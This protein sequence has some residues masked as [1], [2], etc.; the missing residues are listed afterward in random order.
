MKKIIVAVLIA[1]LTLSLTACAGNSG[2]A[3]GGPADYSL[4]SAAEA[5]AAAPMMAPDADYERYDDSGG[6]DAGGSMGGGNSVRDGR[7]IT[8]SAQVSLNTK[9][10]D[11]DYSMI[12][13]LID[14]SGGFVASESM[15]DNS[16]MYGRPTGR[17]ANISARVP[18]G[19]YDTFVDAV[20]GIG[21]VTQKNKWSDDLTAEYFDTE[22]RI[23]LLEIRKER[24]MNY[25]LEAD[26]A[27]S[28][29]AFERELSNVLYELD[30]FQGNKRRLD[31]LVDYASVDIYLTELITPETIGKDGE[32]LGDRAREAFSLSLTGVGRFLENFA[33]GFAA[34]VP[35]IILLLIIAAII[36]AIV[37]VTRPLRDKLYDRREAR[38]EKRDARHEARHARRD[39]RRRKQQPYNAQYWQ[40]P[41]YPPPPG[42]QPPPQ[43]PQQPPPTTPPQATTP[44]PPAPEQGQEPPEDK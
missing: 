40:Q 16:A 25:L 43:G 19:D 24:L 4:Y 23:E 9:Q 30:S 8:F 28:I 6:V 11:A 39:A 5:P 37:R 18:A 32:P 44:P 13:T 35:V 15:T 36:W 10:F 22:A 3:G 7:K 12:Y 29:V 27:E 42:Y 17:T 14:K 38:R 26:D 34:A 33:V 1:L 20:S 31:R 21:E 41:G 2:R